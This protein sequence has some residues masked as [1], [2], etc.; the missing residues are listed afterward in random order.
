M[1]LSKKEYYDFPDGPKYRPH[2]NSAWEPV[3]LHSWAGEQVAFRC[4]FCGELSRADYPICPVCDAEM[5]HKMEE[6]EVC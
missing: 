2:F 5:F 4:P 6:G 1:T 3:T